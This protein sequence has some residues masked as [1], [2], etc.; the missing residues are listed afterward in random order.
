AMADMIYDEHSPPTADEAVIVDPMDFSRQKRIAA[1]TRHEDLLVPVLRG[2]RCIYD[3]PP[4]SASRERTAAQL[5]R[6]HGGVKRFVNPHQYPVGLE[7][8]LHEMKTRL[9][10]K[11]RGLTSDDEK[12]WQGNA[13]VTT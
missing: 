9:I 4:L 1:R 10:L 11:A 3:V 8:G 2:G 5:A 7:R 6:F 12:P 13:D